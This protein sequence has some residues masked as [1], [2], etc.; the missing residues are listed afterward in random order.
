MLS[1]LKNMFKVPDLRNKIIFTLFIIILFRFGS[2]VPVPGIDFQA[3]QVLQ[4]QAR[5][6]GVLGF[7]NLFSGGALTRFA[8]FGLGIMPYIT[9][10]IIVQLLGVV[11]PKLEQWRNEGAVGQKKITQTTR[12][13]TVAL[14]IMQSTGLAF[15]FHR[16]G[17]A[18]GIPEGVDLIPN[19]TVPRVLLV[20]LS[21]TAG[22]AFIMWLGELVTQRGIGQGMSILIFSSVVS[23]LPAGGAAVR[24]TGGDVKFAIILLLTMAIVVSIV[25]IEQGQ[26]RIPVQFAKR[27]VGRRMYGGQSTY[28]PLKVNQSGVIPIIFASSV[29]SFP[30]LLS[31]VVPWSGVASFIDN[32]LAQPTSLTYIVLYGLMIILFAYFYT[33]IAFDPHQQSD[34]IRKQGGYIP[35]IRPGLQTEKHLAG[36]LNRI[37]LPGALFLAFIALLPSLFLA[38]WGIDNYP[39]AG[40]T[41]LIA[42]GVALE[43]MKQIDSQLMMRNYEGFL[44]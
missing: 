35:G 20:V 39:F 32:N 14:A 26:R 44:K 6:S 16:G 19:F 34:I 21:M 17:S 8:V 1:S 38:V 28:I 12:Y 23:G 3:V 15:A 18:L 7:L 5:A 25:F 10:S 9:S 43:T 37:T 33:A 36:I 30:V 13:L 2:H 22:T 29:L 42:V 24:A 4:D 11:I 27:V 41:L 40:T 31:N